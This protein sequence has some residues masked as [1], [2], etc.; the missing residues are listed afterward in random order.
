M[1]TGRLARLRAEIRTIERARAALGERSVTLAGQLHAVEREHRAVL[2]ALQTATA[3]GGARRMPE[4]RALREAFLR[5]GDT[6]RDLRAEAADVAEELAALDA[7]WE[8]QTEAHRELFQALTTL[9]P[10]G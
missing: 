8:R 1:P 7:A 5:T 3:H 9:S 2:R 6:W 10:T 4:V